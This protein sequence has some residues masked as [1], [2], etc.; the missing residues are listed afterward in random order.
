MRYAAWLLPMVL[1]TSS[2][3]QGPIAILDARPA[4]DSALH[5]DLGAILGDAEPLVIELVSEGPSEIDRED[6]VVLAQSDLESADARALSDRVRASN[7]V[8]LEGGSLLTWHK[9]LHRAH[10]P[11]RLMYALL[12]NSREGRALVGIGGAGAALAGAGI[13]EIAD[14]GEVS[15]NPRRTHKLG[16]RVALG[17]GPPA[18]IDAE[19]WGGDTLRTLRLM[20]RSYMGQAAHLGRGSGLVLEPRERRVRVLGEGGVVFF[21]T[22]PGH[23][24]RHDLRGGRVSLLVRGDAW[25]LRHGRILSSSEL[26]TAPSPRGALEVALGELSRNPT[27]GTE[28]E[29]PWGHLLLRVRKDTRILGAETALRPIR[30]EFD[31]LNSP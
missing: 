1:S 13:V 4:P 18:L 14:L 25:D 26:P 16:A 3:A 9:T 20:E 12:S 30:A 29:S 24:N 6:R 5:Q 17:W 11:T 21:E 28:L 8:V 22:G 15:R 23:R 19:V 2:F 31:L 10:R 27:R 7:A